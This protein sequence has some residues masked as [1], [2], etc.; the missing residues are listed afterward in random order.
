[1]N[2]REYAPKTLALD[3]RRDRF[4]FRLF[5]CVTQYAVIKSAASMP[6]GS[7]RIGTDEY[8]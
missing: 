3:F 1:M 2:V 7:S 4:F 5:S 6:N 8:F